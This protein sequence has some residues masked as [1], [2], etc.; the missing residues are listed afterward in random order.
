MDLAYRHGLSVIEDAAQAI[1]SE[2]KGRRAGSVGHIGSFSFFP[3]KNLGAFGDAG[4]LTTND[5]KIAEDLKCIRM[6]GSKVKY[7]HERVGGNFRIDALQAAIL[8]VK[9][10]HLDSWTAGRRKNADEYRE[11]FQQTGLTFGGQLVTPTETQS[12]H[13]FNQ[14]VVRCQD[15]DQLINHLKANQVG[16]EIYYPVPLHLQQCFTD[17]G[18]KPGDMPHSEL[19]AKETLALPIFP[20]LTS[21]QKQKSCCDH[22]VVLSTTS[23]TCRGLVDHQPSHVLTW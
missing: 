23:P 7:Y 4:G 9:L 12:R 18:Y 16:C 20:E 14:F 5:P 2:Y 13:I 19:A 6:H 21:E 10:K 1:G 3:S 17:L 22:L 8:R 15:R 11:L